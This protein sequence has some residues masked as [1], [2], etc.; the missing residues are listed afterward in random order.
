M[1]IGR[2]SSTEY[3]SGK[4]DE[5]CYDHAKITFLH[6]Q[7][8]EI[9]KVVSLEYDGEEVIPDGFKLREKSPTIVK[10]HHNNISLKYESIL[11]YGY[12]TPVL[13]LIKHQIEGLL[14]VVELYTKNTALAIN[15][16]RIKN[17]QQWANFYS[18][19][20]KGNLG[21]FSGSQCQCHCEICYAQG[22]P[23]QNIAKNHLSYHEA[24]TR[25]KYY[26][27]KKKIGIFPKMN[28]EMEPFCNPHIVDILRV[29]RKKSPQEVFEITTNGCALTEETIKKLSTLKPIF[30][31]LSL[32]SANPVIRKKV[33]KDPSPE[34]A[35]KSVKLLQKYKIPFLGS[36]VAWPSIPLQD[37]ETTVDY[38]SKHNAV[39][40]RILLPGYTQYHSKSLH[41][42]SEEHWQPIVSLYTK[43]LKSSDTILHIQP[44]LYWRKDLT[45]TIE[46]VFQNSPAFHAGL[47]REDKIIKINHERIITRGQAQATLNQ[48]GNDK[49]QR[50]ILV[51]VERNGTRLHFKLTNKLQVTDD[52]YPYKPVGYTSGIFSTTWPYG[53]FMTQTFL[54]HYILDVEHITKQYQAKQVLIFSS[55]LVQPLFIEAMKIMRH[56][57]PYLQKIDVRVTIAK[58]QFWGGNI[59]IADILLVQDFIHHLHKLISNQYRPDLIIIPSSFTNVW[60]F[61]LSGHS[62][63][64][65]EREFNI[66][67]ELIKCVRIMQ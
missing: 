12:F 44:S 66:P 35:I 19:S 23:L 43:L 54:L 58:H 65:I 32:N 31:V 3:D 2:T 67:V 11:A 41:F 39:L 14:Q 37:I 47:K 16:F 50:S 55:L 20:L 49:K 46:G 63:L 6:N 42:N 40:I 27:S 4:M 15:G 45:P 53:I 52:L 21:S 33:M 5:T 29:A 56:Y 18:G 7:L 10:I 30:I 60:G 61:D 64:E 28:E 59:M 9:L 25:I 8:I 62:Y 17:I 51:D 48:L 24:K 38:L 34:T 22:N 57:V 13:S 26:S 1:D 36:I